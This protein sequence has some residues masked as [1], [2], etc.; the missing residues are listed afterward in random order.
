MADTPGRSEGDGQVRG[1]AV[2]SWWMV[3]LWGVLGALAGAA[4]SRVAQA[5]L[6]VSRRGHQ[7]I[8][9]MTVASATAVLFGLL[10]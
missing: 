8:K 7:L 10:A 6:T 4:L 9:A 5:S 3:P 1:T 2:S